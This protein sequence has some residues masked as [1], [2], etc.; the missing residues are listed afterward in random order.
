MESQR[1]SA[2]AHGDHPI[3]A[4]LHDD[5]VRRLL[6]RA[7]PAGPGRVLDLG[8][9]QGQ[10]LARAL[11]ERPGLRG[12]GVDIDESLIGAARKT[13][14]EADLL[15]R[16]DLVVSDA[17][18][19]T[20]PHRFDLVLAVGVAHVFGGLVPTLAAVREHLA[21]TGVAVVGDGFWE[22][23]PTGATLDVGFAADEYADLAATV[24]Q[25]T[26]DGWV[27]VY[28]HVSTTQ[29]WDDYEF[30]WTGTLG[31]WALDHPDDSE[32]SAALEIAAQHRREYLHGYRGTLGFLTVVLRA[33]P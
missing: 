30:S 32:S 15:D 23:E 7:A 20:F 11:T 5:S 25:V 22:R 21:A 1:A 8:C 17:R 29:E 4:P 27:P 6:D 2:V 13:L 3:A 9:G 33:A 12:T 28:A 16:S 31:R 14:A 18:S 24:D 10:W 26:G 19:A